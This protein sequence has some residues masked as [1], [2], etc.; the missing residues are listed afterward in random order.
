MYH[1]IVESRLKETANI[2]IKKTNSAP[3]EASK[4]PVHVVLIIAQKGS[5]KVDPRD[6]DLHDTQPWPP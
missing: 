3:I 6:L 4:V 2:S 5:Q 1:S